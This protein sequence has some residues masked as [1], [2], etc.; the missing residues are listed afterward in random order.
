VRGALG[1]GRLRMIRQLL[2][3][4]LLL[5]SL[6][7]AIGLLIAQWGTQA[8]LAFMKL[9]GD[10][11]SFNVSPD[12]RVLLF[13]TAAA[14]LT[15]LLFG[16]APALRGSRL[17]LVTDL[18]GTSGGVAGRQRLNQ[19]L[20]VGQVALSLALLVGA[21]LFIRTLEKLKG[22][23]AGFDP[24]NVLV[25]SLDSTTKLD[26]AR[27]SRLNKELLARLGALPG[28]RAASLSTFDMLSGGGWSEQ[29]GAD[30]YAARPGED[31]S[32]QGLLVSPRFFE[33]LSTPILRGRDFGAQDES[34][35]DAGAARAAIINQTMAR[36][37][38]GEANPVG[39]YIYFLH[40]PLEKFEV[41]GVTQDT[42][43]NSLREPAPPTYYLPVFRTPTEMELSFVLRTAG[44]PAPL[45]ASIHA[46]VRETDP[47][48]QARDMRTMNDV[49]NASVH[50]ERVLAQLGGFFSLFALSLACLGLYGV[51]S[52][53]VVQRTR[54]IGVRVALGAQ[55]RDVLSLVVGQ[56]LKLTMIGLAIGL[57]A[58]TA[59]TRLVASMLYG[60]TTTD[61]L[62]LIGGSLL[63]L[64]VALFASWLPARR[65]ARVD[66]MAALR[67]E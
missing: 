66:P 34:T 19:S 50:Q 38:F 21:G 33:T 53:S 10:P 15:G 22:Q 30:G 5:A 28:V 23:D 36:R 54:E 67:C 31:L 62:T 59:A 27:R 52:F 40:K 64:T 26:A 63:M 49:V 11:V 60:V 57:I 14:L 9:Q 41:V 17:D 4:S 24:E 42:K 3:E 16:L 29:M 58:A 61:P 35:P 51:L 46:A 32:C 25:F 56:G 2:T 13:T 47:S 48:L 12:T 37:Y 1:A 44:D 43:S 65:A 6:G 39:R 7:A 18:K 55:K 8:L 45:M 20:V